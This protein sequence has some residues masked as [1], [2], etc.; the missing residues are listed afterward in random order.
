MEDLLIKCDKCLLNE[1]VES[2]IIPRSLISWTRVN[3]DLFIWQEWKSGVRDLENVITLHFSM[4]SGNLLTEHQSDRIFKSI[5][6]SD[7]S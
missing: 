1:R 2:N 5:C 7:A 3:G 6:K 4:L